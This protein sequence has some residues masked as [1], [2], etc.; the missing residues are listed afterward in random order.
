MIYYRI[1]Y[2]D[3]LEYAVIYYTVASQGFAVLSW[4]TIQTGISWVDGFGDKAFGI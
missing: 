1:V 3:L 2:Y 4:G